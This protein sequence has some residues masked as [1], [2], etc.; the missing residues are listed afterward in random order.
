MIWFRLPIYRTAMITTVSES[1]KKKIVNYFHV[2]HHKIKVIPNPVF[3]F[4]RF[5]PRAF[6]KVKPVILQIGTGDHKNLKGLIR[7]V[8]EIPCK[9]IIVGFPKKEEIEEMQRFRIDFEI[10]NNLSDEALYQQYVNC[11]LLYFASFYEGFGLP[12]IEANAVGRAVITSNIL[13]MPEVAGKAAYFVDPADIAA[14]RQ[15]ILKIIND[16]Y[17]RDILVKHGTENVKRFSLERISEKYLELY[18]LIANGE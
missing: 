4:F 12:I 3:N 17:Y 11:D 16:D 7:A 8:K 5:S 13:S 18:K 10:K 15:G 6:N 9:I 14:I 1:T 2:P